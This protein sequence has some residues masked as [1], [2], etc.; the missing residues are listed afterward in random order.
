VC[1]HVEDLHGSRLGGSQ[2]R[3]QRNGVEASAV[4][5]I[6]GEI[7]GLHRKWHVHLLL[8]LP[9]GPGRLDDGE[10]LGLQG[11]ER[12]ENVRR[13]RASG[14]VMDL[15]A[16]GGVSVEARK[17]RSL[18]QGGCDWVEGF[19]LSVRYTLTMGPVRSICRQVNCRCV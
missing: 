8:A 11:R 16:K 13:I 10:V 14:W 18:W 17:R 7:D 2:G 1:Q 6:G 4:R 5:G 19:T 3:A 12:D 9:L 15:V